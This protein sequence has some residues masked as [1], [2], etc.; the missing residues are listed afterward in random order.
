[1]RIYTLDKQPEIAAKTLSEFESRYEKTDDYPNIA[2][3]LAESFDVVNQPQKKYEIYQKLLDYL[4]KPENADKNSD[5]INYQ[6]IINKYVLDLTNDKKP[7]QILQIYS[8]EIAKYPDSEWLYEKRVEQLETTNLVDA[9]LEVY[10]TA[11]KKFPT[12][13]WRDKLARWFLKNDRKAEFAEFSADLI[14]KLDDK[15]TAQYLSFFVDS[16]IS[17]TDFDRKLYLALYTA[18]HERFPH[19]IKFINGLLGYHENQKQEN[20]WRELAAKYYFEFPEIR[21]RFVGKLTKTDELHGFLNEAKSKTQANENSLET[22]AYALFKADAAAK[23]SYFEDAVSSYRQLN[24]L[25]PHTAEFEERLI[26]FTR[27]FGQKDREFLE[28]SATIAHNQAD[29]EMSS[30]F[31]RIRSGELQ[32][33]NG[34]YET[35]REEWEKLIQTSAGEPETYLETATV[36]WDYFQ[37]AEAGKT[38]EKLRKK[39]NDETLYAFQ[40]AAIY[41]ARQNLPEAIGEYVKALDANDSEYEYTNSDRAK[42]RLI[43]LARRKTENFNLIK[44]AFSAERSR[45]K[46]DAF[47]VLSYVKFLRD[48]DKKSEEKTNYSIQGFGQL[49]TTVLTSRDKNFITAAKDFFYKSDETDG[50]QIALRRLGQISQNPRD[51]ISYR[52]QLAESFIEKNERPKASKVLQAMLISFPTNYGVLDESAR[53]YW[54]M[55]E[56]E[57]AINVLQTGANRGKGEYKYIFQRK[58]AWHLAEEN[59][60]AEAENV[61]LELHR[62]DA[63]DADVFRELAAVFV[64]TKNLETLRESFDET[65]VSLKKQ[66]IEQREL[67]NTVAELRRQMI[68]AFTT[69]K[70]YDSAI[71]QHIEIINREPENEENVEAAIRYAKRY[72]GASV[73][74]DYYTKTAEEAYKNYRWNV[75]LARLYL[76]ENDFKNAKASY[77]T[78]ILNQPEM[79]ELY[80]SLVEIEVKK[81][82]FDA[83]IKNINRVLELTNDAPEYLRKKVQILETAGRFDEAETV[84]NQLPAE[85]KTQK[86]NINDFQEIPRAAFEKPT[87]SSYV[88]QLSSKKALVEQLFSDM[89]ILDIE[90]YESEIEHH[91]MR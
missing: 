23:L 18:A 5:E 44:T 70:D 39:N 83:A 6:S 62:E 88:Q 7:S 33:E 26:N 77:K 38:I 72:G 16:N 43:K 19:N 2:L 21:E 15:D 90:V 59:R 57:A 22:L 75:I 10:K 71:R 48:L 91:R 8:D 4:G 40:T 30:T 37:Y 9:Q 56:R 42:N 41:E 79:P 54:E 46:N 51:S 73:L 12:N 32:A 47:L 25:Y 45:R 67:N 66:G 35:A 3:K 31:A 82:D 20:Q 78:A 28:E 34:N 64:R 55:N 80:V 29:F 60:L 17:A 27:S 84:R 74:I 63:S 68:D 49:K 13:D 87:P 58:L 76:A 69:F 36:F 85:L 50:E 53:L 24:E 11:F 61:L 65:L 1:M 52:L 89:S 14:G 81:G 86:T